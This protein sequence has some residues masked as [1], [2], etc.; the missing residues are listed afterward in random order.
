LAALRC[1][2]PIV[3][4]GAQTWLASVGRDRTLKLWDT[5]SLVKKSKKRKDGAD[6]KARA[7]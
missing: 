5:S 1:A 2:A 4:R 3:H 6:D 7:R